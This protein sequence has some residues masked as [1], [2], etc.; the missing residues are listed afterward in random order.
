MNLIPRNFLEPCLKPGPQTPSFPDCPLWPRSHSSKHLVRWGSVQNWHCIF[1]GH[2]PIQETIIHT[3]T[4]ST[5]TFSEHPTR[6]A[7]L[8]TIPSLTRLWSGGEGYGYVFKVLPH[9]WLILELGM[10]DSQGRASSSYIYV[11]V[12]RNQILMLSSLISKFYYGN[13]LKL[14]FQFVDRIQ[15]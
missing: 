8:W 14:I 4:H 6:Q 7:L 11:M 10:N 13:L 3:F 5:N 1:D 12:L 2:H 9:R 15:W